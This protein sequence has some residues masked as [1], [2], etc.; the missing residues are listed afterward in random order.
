[1]HRINVEVFIFRS[2]FISISQH[3]D[4]SI[5]IHINMQSFLG[6]LSKYLPNLKHNSLIQHKILCALGNI[7][8]IIRS[9]SALLF[10]QSYYLVKYL[11]VNYRDITSKIKEVQLIRFNL[12]QIKKLRF[13]M[14]S[15]KLFKSVPFLHNPCEIM[16]VNFFI[17]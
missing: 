7:K 13:N 5:C 15:P 3:F 1:M 12:I 6:H 16:P 2:D 8:V 9:D 14:K 17:I 10:V 11:F 4:G